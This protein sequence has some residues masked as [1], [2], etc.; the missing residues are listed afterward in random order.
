MDLSVGRVG[1]QAPY[2]QKLHGN[3]RGDAGR[4]RA[5]KEGRERIRGPE[6]E[7]KRAPHTTVLASVT[8]RCPRQK[9]MMCICELAPKCINGRIMLGLLSMATI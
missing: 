2:C 1:A 8:D 5:K 6:E 9:H 4:R 7:G 3:K